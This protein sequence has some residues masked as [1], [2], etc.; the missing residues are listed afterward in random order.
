MHHLDDVR[1]LCSA[2][3]ASGDAADTAAD[4]AGPSRI[5]IACKLA[6]VAICHAS[7]G[8]RGCSC[9]G[10]GGTTGTRLCLILR[11]FY[12]VFVR[13]ALEVAVG[14]RACM[15]HRR[16]RMARLLVGL[17]VV[18]GVGPGARWRPT[19]GVNKTFTPRK[20]TLNHATC[21]VPMLFLHHNRPYFTPKSLVEVKMAT[22]TRAHPG[23]RPPYSCMESLSS[24]AQMCAQLSEPS[25]D[26]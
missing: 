23:V 19:G 2:G 22:P 20:H 6:A 17:H 5:V 24:C 7:F 11:M 9:A 3:L 25:G 15:F 10:A 1:L 26:P 16:Q 12:I 8:H 4:T 14:V 13:G 21:S 18:H